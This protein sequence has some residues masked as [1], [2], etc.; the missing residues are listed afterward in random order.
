MPAV[1]QV[2]TLAMASAVR[3]AVMPRIVSLSK[4]GNSLLVAVSVKPGARTAG[5]GVGEGVLELRVTAQPQDG[6]A[7]IAVMKAVAAL[8]GVGKSAV[9]VVRGHAAR[10]KVLA[11]AGVPLATAEAVVAR[12]TADGEGKY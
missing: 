2:T 9:S 3:S 11:V 4:D 10:Q 7:N 12:L 8:L 6:E 5:V 1:L